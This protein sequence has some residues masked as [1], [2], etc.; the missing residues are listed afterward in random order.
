MIL[1]EKGIREH[2]EK[3]I[4]PLIAP[5]AEDQLQGASYDIS[6]SGNIVVLKS[7][8]RTID[9]MCNDDLHDM[10]EQIHIGSSGYLLSPGEYVLVELQETVNIPEKMVAHIRPRTRFTRSGILVADQHCN[11]TYTGKLSIGLFNAGVNP[12]IL[13]PKLRIAQMIFEE[14][15]SVPSAQK[16]YKNKKNAA[17]EGEK[18]F[19]GS[20][21][22]EAGWG[23]GWSDA[24]KKLYNDVMASLKEGDK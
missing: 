8:G 15:E 17:F 23:T 5:F 14:I 7:T 1:S 21:F 9:P 13:R 3:L 18:E 10:Y 4:P 12:F 22:A 6:M 2:V 19:R 16:L 20:T 24:G 11:P